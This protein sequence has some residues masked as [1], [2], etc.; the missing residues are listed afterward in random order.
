MLSAAFIKWGSSN[1]YLQPMI[2]A[3]KRKII[4]T[5]E[6]PRFTIL[7]WGLRG[8]KLCKHVFM[9]LCFKELHSKVREF[10]LTFT[11]VW[12]DSA[13]D[14]LM[15]FFSYFS[16]KL[17]FDISCQLTPNLHEISKPI[18]LEN[19]KKHLKMLSSSSWQRG[20]AE[21]G[22]S[23]LS[24]LVIDVPGDLVWDLLCVQ[25]A[26]YLEGGPLVWMLPLYLHVNKKSNYIYDMSVG[27]FTQQAK[28]TIKH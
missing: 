17:D 16:Q 3:E 4:Y 18:F 23:R 28:K 2:W 26:S 24:T 20:T 12:A 21:S 8:S 10:N 15:I 7:K 27:S 5:F 9:M 1:K 6:N 14:K 25:Q 19:Q 13:D 11:I 22:S